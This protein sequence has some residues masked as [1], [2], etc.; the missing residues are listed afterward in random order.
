M[1]EFYQQPP[2]E[3]EGEG[4]PLYGL[5]AEDAGSFSVAAAVFSVL[6]LLCA[7]FWQVA[8]LFWVLALLFVLVS[9]RQSGRVDR[10]TA[11]AIVLLVLGALAIGLTIAAEVALSDPTLAMQYEE[12]LAMM[13]EQYGL[14]TK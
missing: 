5:S 8:L 11:V 7:S 3:G 9:A 4:T 1:S 6:G 13:R 10:P 14:G 12:W 2:V